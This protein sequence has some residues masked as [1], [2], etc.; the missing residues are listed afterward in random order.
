MV[1]MTSDEEMS[2]SVPWSVPFSRDAFMPVE[3]FSNIGKS[4]ENRPLN[5]VFSIVNGDLLSSMTKAFVIEPWEARRTGVQMYAMP[6]ELQFS[7]WNAVRTHRLII[8]SQHEDLHKKTFCVVTM[9]LFL[10]HKVPA[11]SLVR[12]PGLDICRSLRDAGVKVLTL[13]QTTK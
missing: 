9:K 12:T 8:R 1:D 10:W 2:W 7:E 3:A 11:S 13:L 5:V 4:V 6:V